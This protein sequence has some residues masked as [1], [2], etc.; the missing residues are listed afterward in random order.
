MSESTIL[1]L[2]ISGSII[3]S[4]LNV[5]ALRYIPDNKIILTSRTSKGRSHCQSCNATLSWYE[6]IPI[7]SFFI[8]R[9]RC[10]HCNQTLIWQYPGIE[11]ITGLLTASI[12]ALFLGMGVYH[13]SVTAFYILIISWILIS[14]T[15][16]VLSLIDL[17]HQ[18]I[19]DQCNLLILF[20]SGVILATKTVYLSSFSFL[21]SY[22]NVFLPHPNQL[23]NAITAVIIAIALFGGIFLLS[24]GRGIGFGDVKLAIPL[25]IALGYPDVTLSFSLAFIVGAIIGISLIIRKEKTLKGAIPFGPFI[26]IG[27]YITIFYG[28]D[29][30]RWYFSII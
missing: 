21:G 22:A 19:P 29:L 13:Q 2:F 23:I 1:L 3:G 24:R 27:L 20:L 5:L 8:Q 15:A 6:L 4:Y 9:G 30:L 10:R 26:I 14:Y 17:K 16:I 25:A 12:P 28:E 18:I 11:F 7:I